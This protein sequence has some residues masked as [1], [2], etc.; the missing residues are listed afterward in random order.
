[1]GVDLLGGDGRFLDQFGIDLGIAAD[2]EAAVELV[3]DFP[4]LDVLVV[5]LDG[6]GGVVAPEGDVLEGDAA[7]AAVGGGPLG[8]EAPDAEDVDA[9]GLGVGDHG[10]ALFP[11]P[12]S[13][14]GLDVLPLGEEAQPA[15]A[16]VLEQWIELGVVAGP[17]GAGG[18]APGALI[19]GWEG[20]AVGLG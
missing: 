20:R 19:I 6:F 2:G 17:F 15:D 3:P 11:V 8:G 5:A 12:L 7:R 13:L 14:L 9:V 1:M 4:I 10:V 16:G 18:D